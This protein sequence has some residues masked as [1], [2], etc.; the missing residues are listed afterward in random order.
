MYSLKRSSLN[1][2]TRNVYSN[3]KLMYATINGEDRKNG[4]YDLPLSVYGFIFDITIDRNNT[5]RYTKNVNSVSLVIAFNSF[6]SALFK[7]S[8]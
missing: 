4:A 3:R 8:T 7:T 2:Y 6:S 1:A 5:C